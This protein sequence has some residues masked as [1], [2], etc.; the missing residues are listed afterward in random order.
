[1]GLKEYIFGFKSEDKAVN[2]LRNLNFE[3]IDRNFKSKFGEIDIIAKKNSVLH[4]VEVKATSGEYDSIYRI[5]PI[6]MDKI[7][8]TIDFYLMK[9]KFDLNYQIDALLVQ[10]NEIKFIEN[11]TI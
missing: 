2:Y 8:K 7:L 3:I 6:K 11:I 9:S 10:K 4:F 5:T 1:M